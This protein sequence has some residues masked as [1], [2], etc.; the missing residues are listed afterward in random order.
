MDSGFF[1]GILINDE[2]KRLALRGT[3]NPEHYFDPHLK[4]IATALKAETFALSELVK[5]YGQP[6]LAA[7]M[8]LSNWVDKQKL[9][10]KFKNED[11]ENGFKC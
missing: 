11:S 10:T 4:N 2:D 7:A 9:S 8:H 5:K 1:L 6:T 3:L